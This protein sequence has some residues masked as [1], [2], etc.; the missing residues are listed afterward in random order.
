MT[1]TII[2]TLVA[3]ILLFLWQFLSWSMLNVHGSEMQYTDKQDAVMQALSQNLQ[4][5]S[6]Y[7][8]NLPPGSTPEQQEAYME[9]AT[10]KPWA[11]VTYH[12]AMKTNMGMNMFRGLVIDLLSAFLLIWLLGK[13][14]N[15]SFQTILMSALA[16][17]FIGYF[18]IPYLNTIWFETSSL[19]YLIDA[20]V[21][22]GLVGVWLG[23]YL[24]RNRVQTNS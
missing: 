6:Y 2:A 19:S 24:P 21:Q 8:P 11:T 4:E 5:G 12:E 3:G 15:P 14:A 17:G 20:V 16:V 10:G 1:K 9:S 23:W 22:W 7:L 18:T 13:M